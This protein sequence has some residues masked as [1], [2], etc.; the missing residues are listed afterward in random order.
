M[1]VKAKWHHVIEVEREVEVDEKAFT[2]W[3]HRLYG[4]G[5]DRDLALTVWIEDLDTD[6]LA[7]VFSDWRTSEPLPE[8]FVLAYSEVIDA[9]ESEGRES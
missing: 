1:K 9:Q 7:E 6:T 2:E 3:M 8:D 4:E 5:A